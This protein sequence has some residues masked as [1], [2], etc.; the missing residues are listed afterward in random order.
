[1]RHI[2]IDPRYNPVVL[3]Q[4]PCQLPQPFLG[5]EL[6]TQY[7]TL[8]VADCLSIMTDILLLFNHKPHST[9]QKAATK[10]NIIHRILPQLRLAVIRVDN[11]RDL[12]VLDVGPTLVLTV[13]QVLAHPV[14]MGSMGDRKIQMTRLFL[15]RLLD[16][17]GRSLLPGVMTGRPITGKRGGELPWQMEGVAI[18]ETMRSRHTAHLIGGPAK[19][20][21]VCLKKACV[22]QGAPH[23]PSLCHEAHE[24]IVHQEY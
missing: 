7:Q 19:S 5:A 10:V 23:P 13:H 14:T 3:L 24:S 9:Y 2:V 17:F 20:C 6:Q 22:S 1:M 8:L 21:V 15:T 18:F 16:G 12:R 11:W 4:C